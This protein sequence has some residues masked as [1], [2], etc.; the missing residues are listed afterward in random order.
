MCFVFPLAVE[1]KNDIIKVSYNNFVFRDT[2]LEIEKFAFLRLRRN[3]L[4]KQNVFLL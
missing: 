2:L 3:I 4:H 1:S